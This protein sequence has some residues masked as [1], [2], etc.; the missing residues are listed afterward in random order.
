MQ[1]S[2]TIIN[3]LRGISQ[4][5][6]DLPGNHPFKVPEGYFEGLAERI[7][8]HVISH[9]TEARTL[10][11][12][13]K[14]AG[15]PFSVPDG[16]FDHLA[17]QV[18]NRIQAEN[19]SA[20]EEINIL[21]PLLAKLDKTPLLA[22]PEGY[23]EETPANVVAGVQALDF[24][25][26]ELEIVSPELLALKN[27]QVFTVPEG[28]FQQFPTEILK[29]VKPSGVV[30]RG[31]FGKKVLQYAA[32]AAVIGI[33]AVGVLLFNRKPEDS[34]VASTTVPTEIEA[35]LNKISDAELAKYVE[36]SSV[37][38]PEPAMVTAANMGK[39]DLKE[40]LTDV[41]DKDLESYLAA[42]GITKEDLTN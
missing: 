27:R 39:E 34:N 24:V 35:S 29:K 7:T 11:E 15:T 33:I 38:L 25:Q 10:N 37:T 21:S 18:L 16:Y 4:V 13:G 19:A 31:N 20:A 41:S 6:A 3:E 22:V 17:E 8:S 5:V 36:N 2:N 23:F 42:Y 12:D 40:M 1:K 26:A 32:A 14:K 28:Y 9:E 30:I